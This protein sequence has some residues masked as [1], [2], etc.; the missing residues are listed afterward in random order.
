[1]KAEKTK[2]IVEYTV[3][4]SKEEV[5]KLSKLIG[6]TSHDQRLK[7]GLAFSSH[8]DPLRELYHCLWEAGC[9]Y[10]EKERKNRYHIGVSKLILMDLHC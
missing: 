10:E 3:T 1:M 2:C 5:L 7:A 9:K 8:D 4:L 6:D